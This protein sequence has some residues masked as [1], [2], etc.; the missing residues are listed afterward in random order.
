MAS[1]VVMNSLLEGEGV[2]GE[3]AVIEHSHLEGSWS[4]G[5]ASFVSQIHSFAD[6]AVADEIAV[7]EVA[8]DGSLTVS[9]LDTV[10]KGVPCSTTHK[11]GDSCTLVVR[12]EACSVQESGLFPSEVTLSTFM[13]SYQLYELDLQGSKFTVHENNPKNKHIYQAGEYTHLS[14]DIADIHVI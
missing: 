4:V 10:L 14:M 7:Q 8:A 5:R 11:V 1:S 9:V 6:L 3:Q 13:G 2:A 12:P